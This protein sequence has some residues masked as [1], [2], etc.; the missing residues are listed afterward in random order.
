[1]WRKTREVNVNTQFY[2]IPKSI[3][4]RDLIV[5]S[6]FLLPYLD[7]FELKEKRLITLSWKVKREQ[8][9]MQPPC[10]HRKLKCC[11]NTAWTEKSIRYCGKGQQFWEVTWLVK[12]LLQV[13]QRY[14]FCLPAAASSLKFLICNL[15]TTN[16]WCT[17]HTAPCWSPWQSGHQRWPRWWPRSPPPLPPQAH[18]L[19]VWQSYTQ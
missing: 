7:Y 6:T 18:T 15:P 10:S 3:V 8:N 16:D 4:T 5:S 14:V 11:S 17:S 9:L 13:S 2:S 12:V 19:R 1:M